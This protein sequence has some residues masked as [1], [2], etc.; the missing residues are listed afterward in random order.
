MS[1]P[2]V[3][4]PPGGE[5]DTARFYEEERE[6]A[7]LQERQRLA[8]ELHDSVSQTLYAV[9]LGAKTARTLLDRDPGR[10]AEALDYVLAQADVGLTEMQAL[11]VELSPPPRALDR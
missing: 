11:I 2:Q 8:R 3:A 6:A 4:L 9:A 5:D 1:D 7:V 10:A